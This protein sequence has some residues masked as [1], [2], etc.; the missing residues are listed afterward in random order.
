MDFIKE[1]LDDKQKGLEGLTELVINTV[2]A[3]HLF[4]KGGWKA[5]RGKLG[6]KYMNPNFTMFQRTIQDKAGELNIEYAG[7][8]RNYMADLEREVNRK[9]GVQAVRLIPNG[10]GYGLRIVI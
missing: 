2:H 1:M 5:V 9:L 7:Y 3:K 8:I 10:K 4:R 6:N